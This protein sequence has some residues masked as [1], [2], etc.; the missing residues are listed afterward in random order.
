MFVDRRTL[1]D[2]ARRPPGCATKLAEEGE[3]KEA[4]RIVVRLGRCDP[5]RDHRAEQRVPLE[6]L[7]VDPSGWSA[8]NA[9]QRYERLIRSSA[10]DAIIALAPAAQGGGPTGRL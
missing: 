10:R 9:G 1:L 5:R 8:S 6:A 3:R 4:S 7:E 2:P